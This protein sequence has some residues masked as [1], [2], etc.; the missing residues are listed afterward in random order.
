MTTQQNNATQSPLSKSDKALNKNPMVWMVYVSLLLGGLL[1]IGDLMGW[2][3]L[4][5]WTAQVGSAL[6]FSAVFL[7]I[8]NGR[9]SGFIASV[10]VWVSALIA[11]F[12]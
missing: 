9:T 6:I 12:N 4:Y 11:V 7:L 3:H 2:M 5:R 10:I 1:I 8:G